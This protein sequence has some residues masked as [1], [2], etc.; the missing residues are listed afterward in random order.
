VRWN[1]QLTCDAFAWASAFKDGKHG[2][3]VDS[4]NT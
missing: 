2:P 1:L 3:A 4:G